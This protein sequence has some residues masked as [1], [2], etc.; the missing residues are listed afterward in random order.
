MTDAVVSIYRKLADLLAAGKHYEVRTPGVRGAFVSSF[1]PREAAPALIDAIDSLLAA[2][3]ILKNDAAT[4]VVRASWRGHDIVIKR[5]ND[6]GI[7]QSLRYMLKGSRAKRA[8]FHGRLLGLIGVPTPEPLAYLEKRKFG[9][10]RESLL[11]TPYVGGLSFLH[12]VRDEKLPPARRHRT[13]EQIKDIMTALAA[14]RISHG[15]SK[16]SNFLVASDG[17]LLTD[18]DSMRVHRSGI[19]ARRRARNDM[20]RFMLDINTDDI[21]PQM[22]LLCA[23]AMGYTGPL[24]Y[25]L[26]GN[27]YA[28]ANDTWSIMLRRGF[29]REDALAIVN[30]G[31]CRDEKRYVRVTSSNTA[32]VYTSTAHHRNMVIPVYVKLHLPRSVVD[33]LKHLLRAGRGRRAFM[34]SLMLRRS[35]LDCP[36]PLALFEKRLGP[37]RTDSILVTE[38]IPDCHQLH[39]RLRSLAMDG[40]RRARIEKRTIIREL[41]AC[42]GRMHGAGIFHGDLRTGNVLLQNDGG[43]WRFHLID[44][45][46]T[47]CFPVLPRRRAIKNIVQLNM[48]RI[49][50]SNSDRMRFLKVYAT[51]AGL[52]EAG[53]RPFCKCV[54][55]N[56]HR[57][58]RLR[59]IHHGISSPEI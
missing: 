2:G 26:T 7:L 15:D 58:L 21:S 50:I 22:K 23:S 54:I 59:A 44:N 52:A 30:G 34:A 18:L 53:F 10:I 14:H 47:R 19:M 3:Q 36:E 29:N 51:H 41:G 57:R 11:I 55:R 27:Y 31:F 25:R 43:H 40:A 8:W 42:I 39:T 33:F 37:F 4:T 6:R 1:C 35:G 17:P 13:A 48:F 24:P 16:T 9:L 12:Y 28:L 56:T 45:E 32:L 49:G 20:M 5:Y 46:R 38:G